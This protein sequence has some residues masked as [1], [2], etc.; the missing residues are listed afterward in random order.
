MQWGYCADCECWT[1][2]SLPKGVPNSAFG[3]RLTALAS[4][5]S[6]RYRLTKRLVQ[7][8]LSNVLGTEISLGSVSKLE[9]RI[10]TS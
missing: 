4:L 3:V 1:C 6:G 7:D 5:L 9:Q 8:I 10:Q 2:G